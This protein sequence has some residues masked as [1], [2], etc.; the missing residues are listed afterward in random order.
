M[1]HKTDA[2]YSSILESPTLYILL[3]QQKCIPDNWPLKSDVMSA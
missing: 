2:K 3:L 1:D